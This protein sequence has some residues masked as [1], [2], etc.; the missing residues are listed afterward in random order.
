[1]VRFAAVGHDFHFFQP[2]VLV[3][4]FLKHFVDIFF[5]FWTGSRVLGMILPGVH[6]PILSRTFRREWVEGPGALE[7]IDVADK[8]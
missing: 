5:L 1:M 2:E 6:D 3:F 4:Q 7:V 8:F